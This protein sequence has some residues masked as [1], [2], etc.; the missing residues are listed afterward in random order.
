MAG[1]A[2]PRHALRHRRL[3]A[4]AALTRPSAPPDLRLPRRAPDHGLRAAK[5]PRARLP[6]CAPSCPWPLPGR[7]ALPRS[8]AAP[9]F[10]PVAF[11]E[12]VDAS[13]GWSRLAERLYGRT[14]AAIDRCAGT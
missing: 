2:Q 7:A 1:F 5:R 6:G 8:A 3:T 13:A 10:V 4:S 14:M 11:A 12:H 9:S